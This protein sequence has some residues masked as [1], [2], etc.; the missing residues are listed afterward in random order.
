[1]FQKLPCCSCTDRL[2]GSSSAT[3]MMVTRK[4]TEVV[5]KDLRMVNQKLVYFMGI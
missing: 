1:M 3:V 2:L 5:E 4:N